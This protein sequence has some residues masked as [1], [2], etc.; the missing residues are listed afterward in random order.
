MWN[1]VFL[2]VSLEKDYWMWG[3]R[4]WR[5]R[6]C[7]SFSSGLRQRVVS[8]VVTNVPCVYTEDGGDT[9]LQDYTASQPRRLWYTVGRVCSVTMWCTYGTWIPGLWS[10]PKICRMH[11]HFAVFVCQEVSRP[12]CCKRKALKRKYDQVVD[13]GLLG[14]NAVWTCRWILTF[15]TNIPSPS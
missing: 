13:V 9:F 15:R 4:F 3:L 1:R 8:Q 10:G 5:R 2:N 7:R 12:T 11:Q 14:C 6:K